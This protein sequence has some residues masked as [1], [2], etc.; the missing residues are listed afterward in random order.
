MGWRSLC[1]GSIACAQWL[2]SFTP[3]SPLLHKDYDGTALWSPFNR[4]QRLSVEVWEVVAARVPSLLPALGI[5]LTVVFETNTHQPRNII[6]FITPCKAAAG[7]PQDNLGRRMI[8]GERKPTWNKIQHA[9]FLH[10]AR[11]QLCEGDGPIR[12]VVV[13]DTFVHLR[14]LLDAETLVYWVICVLET[15]LK[16]HQQ[17]ITCENKSNAD[18]KRI[19]YY[20]YYFTTCIFAITLPEWKH[21]AYIKVSPF[22][23]H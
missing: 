3:S 23:S 11:N 6:A 15:H 5:V 18:R 8:P 2:S 16:P 1:T 12:A 17:Y 21:I 14:K 7:A 9:V 10:F 20:M 22:Y 4:V 19:L 13:V